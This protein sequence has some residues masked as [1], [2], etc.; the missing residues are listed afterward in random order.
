MQ[1]LPVPMGATHGLF[2]EAVPEVLV[3]TMES[4]TGESEASK[5][6]EAAAGTGCLP[7]RGS[8]ARPRIHDKQLS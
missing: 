8:K 6:L 2:T 1:V 3:A 5:T 4:C 7:R